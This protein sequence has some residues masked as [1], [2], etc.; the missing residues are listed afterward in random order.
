MKHFG[1]PRFIRVTS[2]VNQSKNSLLRTCYITY[3]VQGQRINVAA[4]VCRHANESIN[5]PQLIG[6]DR[7]LTTS[8]NTRITHEMNDILLWH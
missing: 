1:T 7:E 5:I 2:I 3:T 8:R 6:R 4:M